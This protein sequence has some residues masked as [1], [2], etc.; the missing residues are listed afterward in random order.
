MMLGARLPPGAGFAARTGGAIPV[1]RRTERRAVVRMRLTIR[2]RQRLRKGRVL[3][4]RS[5][6]IVLRSA[7][8]KGDPMSMPLAIRTRPLLGLTLVFL[9][10]LAPSAPAQDAKPA[11]APAA[12]AGDDAAVL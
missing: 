3:A 4:Q 7:L 5:G 2:C 10:T 11:A 12:V 1:S 8:Q 6:T 9:A